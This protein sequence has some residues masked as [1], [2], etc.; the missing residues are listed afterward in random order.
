MH[1]AVGIILGD[2]QMMQPT[3]FCS[4]G[5]RVD[6]KQRVGEDV[7]RE[8]ERFGTEIL[9]QG[10]MT[11][12]R[13]KSAGMEFT[14]LGEAGDLLAGNRVT[15]GCRLLLMIFGIFAIRAFA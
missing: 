1:R 15:L 3:A 9:E 11:R 4:A 5:R 12:D 10:G 8:Q 13:T 2:E 14:I 7:H 6:I